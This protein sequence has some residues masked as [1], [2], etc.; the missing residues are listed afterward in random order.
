MLAKQNFEDYGNR[1]I[2]R[3]CMNVNNKLYQISMN[4]TNSEI[5]NFY[6]RRGGEQDKM[7]KFSIDIATL[8]E[9][10]GLE[11]KYLVQL[12]SYVIRNMLVIKDSDVCYFDFSRNKVRH[13]KS[14]DKIISFIKGYFVRKNISYKLR[15][16]VTKR[17]IKV[18]NVVYTCLVYIYNDQLILRFVRG[19]VVLG[20]DLNLLKLIKDG[21]LLNFDVFFKFFPILGLRI[22]EKDGTKEILG[23]D[24]YRMILI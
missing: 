1:I 22:S 19:W 10:T 14:I 7:N 12:G 21:L 17:K 18:E 9:K 6:I 4:M 15:N 20:L 11:G 16:L 3:T 13:I 23:F 5:L 8:C 2:Y 24:K